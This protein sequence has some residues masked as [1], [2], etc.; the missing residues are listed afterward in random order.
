M[1]VEVLI[2]GSA[3]SAH[4]PVVRVSDRAQAELRAGEA[5]VFDGT[6]LAFCCAVASP[7]TAN[8]DWAGVLAPGPALVLTG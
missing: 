2:I 6:R 3:K 5:L 4:P 7:D 8:E 1:I